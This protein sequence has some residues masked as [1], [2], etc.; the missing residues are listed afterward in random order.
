MHAANRQP[1][2]GRHRRLPEAKGGEWR[3]VLLSSVCL[4]HPKRQN[5][6]GQQ[7]RASD[8]GKAPVSHRG[9]ETI[10]GFY[11]VEPLDSLFGP[12]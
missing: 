12:R 8:L 7:A 9:T 4:K 1:R 10:H 5:E 11:F 6:I 3:F 2:P